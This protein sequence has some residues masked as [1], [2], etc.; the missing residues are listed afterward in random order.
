VVFRNVTDS[1]K[2]RPHKN[3]ENAPYPG[4]WLSELGGDGGGV[5]SDFVV[6]SLLNKVVPVSPQAFSRDRLLRIRRSQPTAGNVSPGRRFMGVQWGSAYGEQVAK[7]S[8][9]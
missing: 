5:P 3:P 9:N 8:L 7:S 2:G 1:R 6:I 4:Q